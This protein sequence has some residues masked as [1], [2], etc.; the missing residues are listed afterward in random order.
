MY[1]L[2]SKKKKNLFLSREILSLKLAC[3]L[4]LVLH[5]LILFLMAQLINFSSVFH[6]QKAPLILDFVLESNE[7]Y[8]E[9]IHVGEGTITEEDIDLKELPGPTER[10]RRPPVPLD[11]FDDVSDELSSVSD[12]SNPANLKVPRMR[13]SQPEYKLAKLQISPRHQKKVLKHVTKLAERLQKMEMTDSPFVWEDRNQ[14]FTARIRHKHARAATG[15]DTVVY[16]VSTT[17]DGHTLTTEVYMR[18]LAFSSFA[19]FVDY[20][21]PW[22]AVHDDE[23]VGWFH[24]NS[25]FS[26]SQD[27]RAGPKFHGKVTTTAYE[28]KTY[29]SSPFIDHESIFISG[30][31]TGV[32]EIRLPKTFSLFTVST[33]VDSERI[34]FLNEETWI[35]FRGNGSYSWKAGS[36]HGFR[37]RRII[38][39]GPYYIVGGRKGKIH[40]KGMIKGKV[41]VYSEDD[42]IIDDDLFYSGHPE[43]SKKIDDFLGLVSQK[44]IEI[45]HPSV[46]GPGDLNIHAAIYARRRFRISHLH[47]NGRAL[48]H[49]HG[50]LS[51]GSLSATEPR[52][53]TRVV[54]DERLETHRPPDFPMTDHYKI[55]EWDRKW[56]VN[57]PHDL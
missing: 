35:T 39:D 22:I 48:L 5:G 49:I 29:G 6:F 40:V 41:L 9:R 33:A 8:P 50:S 57:Q 25:E 54:F 18:R 2:H 19:H 37:H 42:I 3:F 45:A 11:A 21:D 20:W 23:I 30:I 47:G 26:I 27:G 51:A 4:S 36:S 38:P 24:T 7:G 28:V 32:R 31:E 55:I 13:M 34:H 16:E 15:L 17:E 53:A 44:D 12:I 1:S 52:Y 14:T 43:V 56:T 10:N 46:T